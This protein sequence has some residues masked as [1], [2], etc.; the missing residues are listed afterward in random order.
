MDQYPLLPLPAPEQGPTP[1]GRRF[2]PNNVPS[3]SPDRQAQRLGPVF[4]RLEDV[5]SEDRDDLTLRNDPSGLAPERALVLGLA[6]SQVD[7]Q[8]AIRQVKG[9]EFLG[10][11]ET[12]FDSDEDFHIIGKDKDKYM[13]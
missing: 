4:Q 2:P 7:V 11:D 6:G 9:L 5:L 3:L 10:S 12:L 1:T 13:N 8:A